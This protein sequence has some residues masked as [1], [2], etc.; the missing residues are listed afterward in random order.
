[1]TCTLSEVTSKEMNSKCLIKTVES[2]CGE[3]RRNLLL[4]FQRACSNY[5]TVEK[6]I[7]LNALLRHY[8]HHNQF[9]LADRLI[10]TTYP[11]I[12]K[13]PCAELT[14]AALSMS[15]HSQSARF[16]FYM[17]VVKA[18]KL[19]Y[20]TALSCIL[21][22]LREANSHAL[23]FRVIVSK[24]GIV[25]KLLAGEVPERSTFFANE[26]NPF[27]LPYSALVTCVHNGEL[28]SFQPLLAQYEEV[29]ETDGTLSLIHRVRHSVIKMALKRIVK[30]YARISLKDLATKLNLEH[31]QD[32]EHI[33]CK[34]IHDQVIEAYLDH[35][36]QSLVSLGTE[37]DSSCFSS[38]KE[39][40]KR[41][42]T[43]DAI[44]TQSLRSMTYNISESE[45]EK[46]FEELRKTIEESTKELVKALESGFDFDS[47]DEF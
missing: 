35:S 38:M 28:S 6:E 8:V 17:A 4:S 39:F 15:S 13:R 25:V 14:H 37:Y 18:I 47:E 27:L 45:D 42:K 32:A 5:D 46:K 2:S 30:C 26:L 31:A 36:T 19:E 21:Q 3:E 20:S 40:Q 16:F 44:R 1:M 7:R 11:E 29:F 34:A 10:S 41:I 22:S 24:F 43:C 12:G 9:R 33:A 23:G